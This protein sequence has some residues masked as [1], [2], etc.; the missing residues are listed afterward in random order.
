MNVNEF[1]T[2]TRIPIRLACITPTNWPITI[3]LW[4]VYMEERFFCATQK[5]AL[6]VKYLSRNSRCGFEVASDSSPYLGVRG[7]GQAELN[8]TRGSEILHILIKRYLKDE[9]SQLA[10]FLLRRAEN[11]V[12]I[13]IKP[14]SM[15]HYD[16]ST[17]MNGIKVGTD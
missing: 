4:Y 15:F 12:V 6:I 1:L 3:S 7:S 10:D 8:E 11:E 9:T 14:T 17:R 5:N 16:Y 2:R 13:Q